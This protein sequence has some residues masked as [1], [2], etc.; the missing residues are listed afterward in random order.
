M[1]NVITNLGCVKF[2]SFKANTWLCLFCAEVTPMLE[3]AKVWS[4]TSLRTFLLELFIE[5]H[6]DFVGL[7]AAWKAFVPILI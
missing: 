7:F 1:K 3:T 2:M 5:I 4:W 6:T